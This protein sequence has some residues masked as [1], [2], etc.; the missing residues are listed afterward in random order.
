[1]IKRVGKKGAAWNSTRA[2]I[3][4]LFESKG[5]VR[6]EVCNSDSFLSFGHRL[7]RRFITDQAEPETV[8]LLCVPCHTNIENLPHSE[9]FERITEII[10]KRETL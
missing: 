7:K 8:V 5:I 4:K 3:K 9:M 6:C 2:K 1:M 10:R